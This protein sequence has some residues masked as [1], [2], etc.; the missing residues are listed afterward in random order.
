MF[1]K[2]TAI[3]ALSFIATA[4]AV[5]APKGALIS[6]PKVVKKLL[7]KVAPKKVKTVKKLIKHIRMISAPRPVATVRIAKKL[8]TLSLGKPSARGQFGTKTFLDNRKAFKAA[9]DAHKAFR[10]A[11]E[12]LSKKRNTETEIYFRDL[13]IYIKSKAT[14]KKAAQA[15]KVAKAAHV[16]AKA[17]VKRL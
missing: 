5:T 9:Q 13:A 7:A 11:Q 6:A 12:I 14:A 1:S 2:I 17:E 16:I 10:A 15:L 3:V 4:S 8:P